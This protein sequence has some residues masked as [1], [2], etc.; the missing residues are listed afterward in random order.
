MV[1]QEVAE[2]RERECGP[3]AQLSVCG[4]SAQLSVC[5]LQRNGSFLQVFDILF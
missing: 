4:R 2:V 3:S 1:M 5:G